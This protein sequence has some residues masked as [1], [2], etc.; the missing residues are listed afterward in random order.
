MFQLLEKLSDIAQLIGLVTSKEAK[1]L[2]WR[3]ILSLLPWLPVMHLYHG[4]SEANKKVAALEQQIKESDDSQLLAI[5]A[6]QYAAKIERNLDDF[7]VWQSN[8]N[9]SMWEAIKLVEK[10]CKRRK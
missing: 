9:D 8:Q 7:Q 1:R 4:V 10:M 6:V 5:G 3:V 2:N